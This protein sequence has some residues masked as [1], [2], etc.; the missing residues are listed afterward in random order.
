MSEIAIALA[1]PP[2]NRSSSSLRRKAESLDRSGTAINQV[3]TGAERVPIDLLQ[4]LY[5]AKST[6]GRSS[7][8][9]GRRYREESYDAQSFTEDEDEVQAWPESVV[10]TRT[11]QFPNVRKLAAKDK[12][13]ILITG[14]AGASSYLVLHSSR[15]FE[16]RAIRC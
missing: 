12:K 6:S 13:R 5:L 9:L 16:K 3:G 14:G 8:A 10:Y 11:T 4:S 2:T 15:R 1:A 7:P